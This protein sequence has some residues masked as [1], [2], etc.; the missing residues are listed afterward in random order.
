MKINLNNLNKKQ[1]IIFFISII[2][3]IIAI[4]AILLFAAW[5]N[6]LSGK[7]TTSA[8]YSNNVVISQALEIPD[9]T[10]ENTIFI[11]STLDE[12]EEVTITIDKKL[13]EFNLYY[14]IYSSDP[15]KNENIID[16]DETTN[17]TSFIDEFENYTEFD[18]ELKIT[19]ISTIYFVY[20]KDE[21]ISTSP[22]KIEINNIVKKLQE[23]ISEEEMEAQKVDKTDKSNN[24]ATY[25]I[26]VNYTANV[27]TV[28][29]KDE[30][31]E[32]TI[33]VK[34]MVCSCGTATPHSGVY[35]TSRGYLWGTLFGGVYGKY[36]TRIV[37]AILFH[38]VPYTSPSSDSL[39]YWEFDKLGQTASAGCIRLQVKDSKWI[40]DNCGSGTMVEFYS[41][42][43][44]GP[45]GKPSAPKISSNEECRNWDPTDNEAENPWNNYTAQEEN[46]NSNTSEEVEN[47]GNSNE[48][49]S[50]QDNS[51]YQVWD[52]RD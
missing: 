30:N 1:K 44:P 17:A 21:Q 37:G 33:P 13:D 20:E 26:K 23:E 43:D 52:T 32:Y 16:I 11:L 25:Y 48:D 24:T 4:T 51:I 22:Y 27:V 8:A 19:E 35:K 36:S 47:Q 40:Y 3:L 2:I 15:D 31:G 41:S 50:N 6:R 45:L 12:T 34:A 38:S 49:N 10:D 29:Q 28:Y 7:N 5:K 18:T 14:L 39:E 42:S 9:V 46:T